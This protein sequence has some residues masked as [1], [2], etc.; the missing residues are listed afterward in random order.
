PISAPLPPPISTPSL[1]DALPIY[2]AHED[3]ARLRIWRAQMRSGEK[4]AAIAD[5]DGWIKKRKP[6][7]DD[8]EF[9]P[10]AD[11]F[12]GARSEE[13]YLSGLDSGDNRRILERRCACYLEAA[14]K[15]LAAGDGATAL[16][17]FRK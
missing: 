8:R 5:L 2:S 9:K 4:D 10:V 6:R 7:A 17:Y 16:K 13:L 14:V 11:F 1:H 15:R 3:L 12:L